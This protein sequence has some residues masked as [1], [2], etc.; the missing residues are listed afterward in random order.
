MENLSYK[1]FVP[2]TGGPLT[3]KEKDLLWS[4]N[5]M[6]QKL[7]LAELAFLEISDQ[8]DVNHEVV[9]L[10]SR[11]Y[12]VAELAN[13]EQIALLDACDYRNLPINQEKKKYFIDVHFKP[14]FG[15]LIPREYLFKSVGKE[16]RKVNSCVLFSVIYN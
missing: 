9:G 8:G 2:D 10:G 5:R 7:Y 13:H 16:E 11:K 12:I 15:G 14:F 4:D 1:F 6:I 3:K